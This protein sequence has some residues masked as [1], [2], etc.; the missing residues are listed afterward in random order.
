MYIFFRSWSI[1]NFENTPIYSEILPF[2][3]STKNT[4]RARWQISVHVNIYVYGFRKLQKELLSLKFSLRPLMPADA[5]NY[6][7]SPQKWK[8]LQVLVFP[9]WA[10]F[11]SIGVFLFLSGL[12]TMAFSLETFHFWVHRRMTTFKLKRIG[13]H[14]DRCLESETDSVRVNITLSS[15]S[16]WSFQ[17]I[18]LRILWIS[19]A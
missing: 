12:R 11:S 8:K 5:S 17:K 15:A 2:K 19:C 18:A 1:T 3:D 16:T 4:S 10:L 13:V 14:V 6:L 7:T 9:W